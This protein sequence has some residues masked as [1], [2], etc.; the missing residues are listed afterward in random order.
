M[1]FIFNNTMKPILLLL[2]IATAGYLAFQYT[3]AGRKAQARIRQNASATASKPDSTSA[4]STASFAGKSKE[5]LRV[6][7][8]FREEVVATIKSASDGKSVV[9]A[10][11]GMTRTA[12]ITPEIRKQLSQLEAEISSLRKA[13]ASR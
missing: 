11:C 4:A 10:D 3:P 6:E 13:L 12:T 8:Q 7:L 1:S 5:E 2:A 9:V